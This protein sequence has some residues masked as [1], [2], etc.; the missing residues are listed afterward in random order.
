MHLRVDD[1][2]RIVLNVPFRERCRPWNEILVGQFGVIE[3]CRVTTNVPEI[4]G[5]GE[6]L[7]HYTWERV[8]D[9]SVKRVV[10]R[11]PA[12]FLFDDSLGAGLQIALLD[13]VG[14]ALDVP[15]HRLFNLPRVREWCPIAWWNTKM[16]PE[17]LAAE[18]TDALAEGYLAHKFKARPWFDVYEQVAEM[19]AVTPENYKLDPDWNGMLLD[20]GEATPVLQVLDDEERIGVY[21]TPITMGDIAGYRT[22]KERVRRPIADHF[23]RRLFPSIVRTDALDTFVILN[24]GVTT[25]LR[26]GELC[27]GLSKEFFLQIVGTG[28]TTALTLHLGAVLTHARWPAV[29]AMNMYTDDL[30][31]EPIEI[32]GG[33]AR[34]PDGPGLG[35]VIDEEAFMRYRMEPGGQGHWPQTGNTG[36]VRRFDV[37]LHGGRDSPYQITYPRKLLSFALADGRVRHYA[38]IHQLWHDSLNNGTMPRQERGA[39]LHVRDDDGGSEFDE[40]YRRAAASPIWDSQL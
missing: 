2:E 11:N 35:V 29:T 9:Q 34:V 7:L 18:A 16:P 5:Y 36:L 14:K 1:V 31:T 12:E 22:L 8:S 19:A 17:V 4:V 40:L 37:P 15:V 38:D 3:I 6:T 25:F 27:A 39:R 23:D 28:I 13:L 20:A 32:V 10:G 21:E 24:G 26:E 30:L 33:F